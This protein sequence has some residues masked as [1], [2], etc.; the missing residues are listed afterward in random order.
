MPYSFSKAD[1]A[2]T[3]CIVEQLGFAMMVGRGQRSRMSPFTSGTTNGFVGSFRHAE[4]LSITVVPASTKRGAYCRE[5]SA[6]AEKMAYCGFAAMASSTLTTRSR[7][8][9]NS[10]SFPTDRSDAAAITS[11]SPYPC[12]ASTASISRPTS[13]VAPTTAIFI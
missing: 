2:T 7:R 1:S 13:P 10:I 12:S 9:A 3:I 8:P 5:A 11:S 6:P 4:L